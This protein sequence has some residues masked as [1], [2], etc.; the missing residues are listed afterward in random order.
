MT[1]G[2]RPP[3]EYWIGHLKLRLVNDETVLAA[4]VCSS[5]RVQVVAILRGTLEPP[6]FTSVDGELDSKLY[7]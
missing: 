6:K 5:S 7:V 4:I 3:D 2:A 1:K